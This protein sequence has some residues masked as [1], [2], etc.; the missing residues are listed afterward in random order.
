MCQFIDIFIKNFLVY[1]L[2]LLNIRII[3]YVIIYN[4]SIIY[5]DFKL[6]QNDLLNSQYII[7]NLKAWK[8]NLK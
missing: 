1:L 7:V 5:I 3:K 2:Q 6:K 4:M 8:I